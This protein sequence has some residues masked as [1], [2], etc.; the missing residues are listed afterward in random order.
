[1]GLKA[2]TKT[3]QGE[4]REKV[5]GRGKKNADLSK[6]LTECLDLFI[7]DRPFELHTIAS[8]TERFSL[9]VRE[10]SSSVPRGYPQ[11][12]RRRDNPFNT[13][14]NLCTA[15]GRVVARFYCRISLLC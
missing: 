11:A 9:V 15:S 14:S 1:M 8:C 5:R 2:E 4:G 3:A 13:L 6:K 12:R 10:S 7:L